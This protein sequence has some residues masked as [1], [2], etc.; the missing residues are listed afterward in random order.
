MARQTFCDGLHRRNFL[1]VGAAGALGLN[2]TLPWLLER[3]ARAKEARS[4]G[5]GTNPKDDVS[6]IFLFLKGGLST[7]DTFDLKPQAPAEIRGEFKPIDTSVPGIQVGEHLPRVARQIDKFSLIRSFSHVDSNHGPA[8]H[9]MLT[10]YHPTPS[11]NPNLSPNNERPALGSVIS[12]KLGPRGAAPPYVCVPKMHPSAGSAYLGPGAAPFVIEA[13]P[14]APGFSV[15]DLTPPLSLAASRVANRRELLKQVDRFQQAAE[16]EVNKSA[17][18]VGVFRQKAFDLMTSE[19][20][21]EAFDISREPEQLRDEYGRHSLGQSCLMARR[22]VEAGVRCVSIDHTNWDTHDNNFSVLKNELL[23]DLDSGMSTLFRDLAERGML[24]TTIVLVTGEFG[25]TPRINQNAGRDHW[26]PSFTVMLG[27]GG[28]PGGKVIGASSAHA[29]KPATSPHGPEDLAATV[30]HLLGIDPH[31]EF[32]T[33]ERR[34]V[35]IAEGKV[36]RELV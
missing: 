33:P 12:H 32:Y 31:E 11:F 15:P 7:I 2:F 28:V 6:L 1:H 18:D 23:P 27:G 4:A 9:Y 17:R 24:E 13:D 22:L 14:S 25:R 34:P 19:Q 29:E 21:M 16:A 35:K 5:E 10:G 3:Q 26:G 20:A 30:F 36:I 8:D